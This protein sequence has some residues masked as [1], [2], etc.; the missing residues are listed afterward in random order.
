MLQCV[1]KMCRHAGVDHHA[2]G[3]ASGLGT[4][5]LVLATNLALRLLTILRTLEH[6]SDTGEEDVKCAMC[7]H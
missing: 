3:R 4:R 6:M 7:M 1:Q 2:C 5:Q